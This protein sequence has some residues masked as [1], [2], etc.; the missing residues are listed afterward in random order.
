MTE[1]NREVPTM[2][3][4][5]ASEFY[6]GEA[7]ISVGPD[8]LRKKKVVIKSGLNKLHEF[9]NDLKRSY[10]DNEVEFIR[11]TLPCYNVSRSWEKDVNILIQ[12]ID[13]LPP[14][15]KSLAGSISHVL[16]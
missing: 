15:L 1:A 3:K 9:C 5:Y 14:N 10:M 7:D 13:L 8:N 6:V 12:N 4:F 11:I 16:L 2:L